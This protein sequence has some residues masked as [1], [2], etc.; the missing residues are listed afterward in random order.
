MLRKV[1][2]LFTISII[3]TSANAG[4][5]SGSSTILEIYPSSTNNGILIKHASMPNPD[6]CSPTPPAF[7]ILDKDQMFFNEMFSLIMSAQARSSNINL[8][9]NGCK[10]TNNK[11]PSITLV[12][13]K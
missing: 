11:Y 4:D 6:S 9:V 10:G 1:I 13:A 5:W 7:Y 2:W 8:Y 3:Y 12:I